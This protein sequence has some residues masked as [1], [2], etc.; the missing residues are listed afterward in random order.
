[1]PKTKRVEREVWVLW[2][3][4]QMALNEVYKTEQDALKHISFAMVGIDPPF[5][6]VA[7]PATV[8]VE[9]PS[10]DEKG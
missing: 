5:R 9:V 8:V 7:L 10:E 3:Q 4:N 2:L 6:C 1:M